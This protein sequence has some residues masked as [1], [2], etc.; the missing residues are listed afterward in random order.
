METC[1]PLVAS[2]TWWKPRWAPRSAAALVSPSRCSSDRRRQGSRL[3][4]LTAVSTSRKPGSRPPRATAGR[5]R[6]CPSPRPVWQQQQQAAARAVGLD[7]GRGGVVQGALAW[8]RLRRLLRGRTA[9]AVRRPGGPGH[10]PRGRNAIA[11]P[12][13]PTA[14]SGRAPSWCACKGWSRT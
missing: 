2:S 12:S 3:A 10:L 14:S 9:P 11:A 4:E 6:P 13:V 1:R 7:E 5:R 8:G